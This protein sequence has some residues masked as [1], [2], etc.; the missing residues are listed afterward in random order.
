VGGQSVLNWK[1]GSLS[2][3]NQKLKNSLLSEG[4]KGG[5]RSK[6]FLGATMGKGGAGERSVGN[7]GRKG[8][9]SWKKKGKGNTYD[10]NIGKE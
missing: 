3:K 6:D 1:I 5:I 9:Y 2:K 10:R 7:K 4:G 8:D